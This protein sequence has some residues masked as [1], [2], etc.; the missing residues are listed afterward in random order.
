MENK[1][2][3]W[4]THKKLK[5][6]INQNQNTLKILSIFHFLI[7]F[8]GIYT[9]NAQTP[10]PEFQKTVDSL[11]FIIKENHLAYYINNKK[12][13]EFITKIS[14]TEQGIIS[15]TDSIPSV[16]EPKISDKKRPV[17]VSD[18]CPQKNS[19]KLDLFD[20]ENWEYAYP[21]LNIKSKNN[22]IYARFI[23]FKKL[24]LEKLKEQFKKLKT[25]CKKEIIN[26]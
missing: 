7:S 6:I 4:K 26:N 21:Y 18:C 22:E 1:K 13:G 17:L 20:I 9:T 19:R 14:A 23:G 10:N 16:A 5:I 3:Q 2:G 25:L 24:D 11:N 8:I 12:H 15:F